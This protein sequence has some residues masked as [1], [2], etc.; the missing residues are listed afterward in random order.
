MLRILKYLFAALVAAM[1][2]TGCIKNDVPYPVV[3]LDILAF[4]ADGLSSPAV[5]DAAAHTV[6]V[7]LAETTDIRKLNVTRVDISEGATS[8]VAFPGVFDMRK[9]LYVTLSM[10]QDYEWVVTAQQSIEYSF[11]VEGQIGESEIDTINH[12]VTAYVPMDADLENVV[13]TAAKLLQ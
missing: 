4:E 9:P 2:V 13:I 10:Y 5:I 8:S 11:S 6:E 1:A 3:K 12:I 7:E